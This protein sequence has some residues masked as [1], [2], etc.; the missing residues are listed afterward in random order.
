MSKTLKFIVKERANRSSLW[1]VKGTWATLEL[2]VDNCPRRTGTPDLE[3]AVF[4][5]GRIE[6]WYRGGKDITKNSRQVPTSSG[7][8]D[9]PDVHWSV[10][11]THLTLPTNREV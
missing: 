4:H 11:Y 8:A 6:K 5:Q 1:V 10:S 2:A 9:S 7:P 3:T